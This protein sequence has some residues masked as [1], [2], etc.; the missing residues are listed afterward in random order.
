M[1][2]PNLV[3]LAWLALFFA[4]EDKRPTNYLEEQAPALRRAGA[5]S[6]LKAAVQP[7]LATSTRQDA[8]VQ[9]ALGDG[10]T[11]LAIWNELFKRDASDADAAHQA[12][13]LLVEFGDLDAALDRL[14]KV[15][16][17][18]SKKEKKS[19][20]AVAA[21]VATWRCAV[22]RR[23][24][25]LPEAQKT[26]EAAVLAGA[27]VE[28]QRLLVKIHLAQGA[29]EAA[30]GL[31]KKLTKDEA[32]ATFEDWYGLAQGLDAAGKAEPAREAFERA[33]R[34]MPSFTPAQLSLAGKLKTVAERQ[35]AE[36]AWQRSAF[37]LELAQCWHLCAEL[38]LEDRAKRCAQ[39]ADKIELGRVDAQRVL[40]LLE[41]DPGGAVKEADSLLAAR[42]HP[43]L[44]A[45]KARALVLQGQQAQAREV[46]EA[47]LALDPASQ[48][49][50]AVLARVCA[51][52]G[53]EACA[54]ASEGRLLG[55]K[56]Q[57]QSS[58]SHTLLVVGLVGGALL[59]AVGVFAYFFF[60]KP[61]RIL[62]P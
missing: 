56:E 54:K 1:R 8:R 14:D 57:A 50:H 19:A 17:K 40:H 5:G 36:I 59:A 58:R 6:D 35:A 51:S 26:C 29:T 12:A 15:E 13:M 7:E 42:A 44:F 21:E 39:E 11:E 33:L 23:M 45:A 48:K 47:G 55:E 10:I 20:A 61:K 43:D 53:D 4:C 3:A 41:V 9:A 52:L 25:K 38:E 30:L 2:T 62:P 31:S 37:A 24:Q 32:S 60:R 27:G 46:L 16:A 18:A 22:Q 34:L 28:A 49:I